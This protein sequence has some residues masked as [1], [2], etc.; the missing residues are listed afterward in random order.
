MG[1][2]IH[3]YT[4]RKIGNQWHNI[5]NW[6][7]NE[8]YP[9]EDEPLRVRQWY[10]G[11]DYY[12]FGL[13]ARGVRNDN[14]LGFEARGL[15]A[16]VTNIVKQQ[17]EAWG[18]DAHSASWLTLKELE[19]QAIRNELKRDPSRPYHTSNG[20]DYFAKEFENFLESILY[21]FQIE[22]LDRSDVR[23]VFWFDN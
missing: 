17:Y 4:E 21:S 16:N 19:K 9:E 8:Y 13:L 14:P 11:R 5:D 23:I 6:A 22:E 12:L 18:Y 20:L 2:D 10:D 3:I 15:P 1:C 7:Y